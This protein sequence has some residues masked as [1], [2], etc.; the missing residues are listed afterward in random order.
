MKIEYE[1]TNWNITKI[2]R[3]GWNQ[4]ELSAQGTI[5]LELHCSASEATHF[6][7]VTSYLK[8]L[9]RG[10]ANR[11]TPLGHTWHHSRAQLTALH[12]FHIRLHLFHSD[13]AGAMNGK[14]ATSNAHLILIA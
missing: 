6:T 12:Q 5:A 14:S 2:G 1:R 11:L 7:R 13:T 10:C 9:G 8:Q 4:I 3:E